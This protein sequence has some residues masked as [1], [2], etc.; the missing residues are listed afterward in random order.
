[1]YKRKRVLSSMCELRQTEPAAAI[2]DAKHSIN[3]GC[4]L[5]AYRR[6]LGLLRQAL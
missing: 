5:H 4:K 2:T 6:A 1:M 3:I